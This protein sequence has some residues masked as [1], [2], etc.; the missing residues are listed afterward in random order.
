MSF[1]CM[2]QLNNS[3]DNRVTKD[4]HLIATLNGVLKEETSIITPTI[5][6]DYPA[7]SFAVANY[8]TIPVFN[9]AYYI[10]DIRSITATLTEVSLKV[11]VLSSYDAS[12]RAC[13][14]IVAKQENR[15]NLYL[16]DG[17]F[18][19]YSN[20]NVLTRAFPNGFGND[21]YFILA[22]AGDS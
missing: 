9:R 8:M 13:N 21:F 10:T 20:P 12:I 15:W 5:T 3:E 11:D 4:L 16:D 17:S 6:F 19:T 2:L 14:A 7:T 22:V 1:P 18:K